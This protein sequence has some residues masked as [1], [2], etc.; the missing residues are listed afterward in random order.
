MHQHG[1]K[2]TL[3]IKPKREA[4]KQK[5]LRQRKNESRRH[6]QWPIAGKVELMKEKKIKDD[7]AEPS[8]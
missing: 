5:L 4:A 6:M 8:V 2:K 1:W 3:K 7:A